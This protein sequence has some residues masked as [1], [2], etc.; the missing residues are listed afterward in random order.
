MDNRTRYKALLAEH[1]IT[2][3]ESAALICEYTHKPCAVR[4]VRAWVNDPEKPSSNPCPDW[5][6]N[7]LEA[8]LKARKSN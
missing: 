7:A 5:A 8:S 2:Q 3:A 6:V 4:T 1:A